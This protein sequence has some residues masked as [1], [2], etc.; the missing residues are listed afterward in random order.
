M[1]SNPTS[2]RAFQAASIPP[3]HGRD[4]RSWP[5]H[6]PDLLN[7]LTALCCAVVAAFVVCGTAI[8]QSGPAFTGLAATAANAETVYLNPAGMT[9]LP[10]MQFSVA[11]Q[12]AYYN[13]EF[14]ILPGSTEG[15]GT[16]IKDS[17]FGGIPSVALSYQV[18]DRWWAGIGLTVPVG[19]GSEW[20]DDWAGRYIVQEST[21]AAVAATPSLAYRVND[22]FSI[23]A[24][25]NLNYIYAE[26][27][28]AI[29][30]AP[31]ALPDGR[32]EYEGDGIGVGGTLSFLF[33]PSQRTRFGL[34]YRS[35]SE[36]DVEGT[37]E[38]TN[39]GPLRQFVFQQL[40]ILGAPVTTVSTTPQ[41]VGAGVYHELSDDWSLTADI[42]WADFSE[43]GFSEV[44][45][46]DTTI[47][48]N[49]SFDDIWAGSLGVKRA[50]NEKWAVSGGVMHATAGADAQSRTLSLLLDRIWGVGI[51][52]DY[53]L[54][55]KKDLSFSLTYLDLGDSYIDTQPTPL[56]GRVVGEFDHRYAILL[57]LNYAIR[58]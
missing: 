3:E 24:S 21:Y 30:N 41:S 45:V 57:G 8:A 52:A 40:G 16:S 27:R 32:V 19:F 54:S 43:F 2:L 35:K 39:L 10:G 37:P 11:P 31:D 53:A 25:V 13:N 48:V 56:S 6:A 5:S 50:I 42:V 36:T 28:A 34:V 23:G 49:S 4:R 51:G 1:K 46:G 26:T 58:F 20:P 9:R 7:G 33:E 44:T 12:I 29:N 17:G 15:A 47:A 55:E 38:F 18:N 14:R 22:R